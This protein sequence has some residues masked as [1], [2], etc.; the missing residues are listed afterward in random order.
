MANLPLKHAPEPSTRERASK[1]ARRHPRLTSST[2]VADPD[3]LRGP[4]RVRGPVRPVQSTGEARG[5]RLPGPGSATSPRPSDTCSTPGSSTATVEHG[6]SRSGVRPSGATGSGSTRPG[7]M[8]DRWSHRS[9]STIAGR[10]WKRSVPC[11]CSWPGRAS[12]TSRTSSPTTLPASRGSR[13]RPGSATWPGCFD[14]DRSP[15][16]CS[17]SNSNWH[18][19]WDVGTRRRGSA[20]IRPERVPPRTALDLEIAAGAL[21]SE[22]AIS[23]GPPPGPGGDPARPSR[24]LGLVH[25]RALPRQRITQDREAAACFGTC[26]AL[27]ARLS[28]RLV[29]PGR[30]PDSAGPDTTRPARDLERASSLDP[31]WPEPH[32]RTGDRREPRR[33]ARRC[34]PRLHQG[35]RAGRDR[36]PDLLP[37]GRRLER[38]PGDA[39]GARGSTAR[40]GSSTSLGTTWAG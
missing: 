5:G 20:P 15:K 39:E 31:K 40:R 25:A 3:R 18:G 1:W 19:C 33:Q 11:S 21:A 12:S 13:R 23:Q 6:P 4:G 29:Q 28:V 17:S 30:G 32:R 36:H 7:A 14:P 37:Q 10:S 8:L 38:G 27:R 22:G 24:L 9:D 16:G 35:H 26:I 2:S 34:R